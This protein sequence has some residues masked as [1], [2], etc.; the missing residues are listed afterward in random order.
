MTSPSLLV[1][2]SPILLMALTLVPAVAMLLQ[3]TEVVYWLSNELLP[4]AMV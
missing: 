2:V 3:L 1:K 4:V